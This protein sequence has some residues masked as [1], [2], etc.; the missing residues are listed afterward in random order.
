MQTSLSDSHGV[1]ANKRNAERV[2]IVPPANHNRMFVYHPCPETQAGTLP[3]GKNNH[4]R[5]APTGQ[6]QLARRYHPVAVNFGRPDIEEFVTETIEG[7]AVVA[8]WAPP[9]DSRVP[10]TPPQRRAPVAEGGRP[11]SVRSLRQVSYC[12]RCSLIITTSHACG[13]VEWS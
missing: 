9:A 5:R 11:S 3:G 2:T 8:Q 6:S 1:E 4:R 10:P 13:I 12:Q 7:T